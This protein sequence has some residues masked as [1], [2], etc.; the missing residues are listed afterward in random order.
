[1]S[2]QKYF[3]FGLISATLAI[4]IIIKYPTALEM[5]ASVTMGLI[6]LGLAFFGVVFMMMAVEELKFS[7]VKTADKSVKSKDT[8]I[9]KESKKA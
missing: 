2:A 6:V 7:Q 4:G 1:M 8:K 3:L 5:V 9:K